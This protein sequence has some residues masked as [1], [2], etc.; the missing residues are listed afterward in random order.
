MR[1]GMAPCARAAATYQLAR[2]IG[3]AGDDC[4]DG[5]HRNDA[6]TRARW[7]E[8]AGGRHTGR[9]LGRDACSMPTQR[10]TPASNRR[11]EIY[12]VVCHSPGTRGLGRFVA[13]KC[14][15]PSVVSQ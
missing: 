6:A 9:C 14:H 10:L 11:H 3:R 13:K 5:S 15:L 7:A 2:R 4:G 12:A 8:L 1:R